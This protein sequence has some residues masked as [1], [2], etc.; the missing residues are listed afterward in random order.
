[1]N[2]E[3][4]ML[5]NKPINFI[6]LKEAKQ[7]LRI[8][9]ENDDEM[10]AHMINIAALAA[11]NYLGLKL[12]ETSWKMTIYNH[13]PISIKFVNKPISKIEQVKFIRNNKEISYLLPDQYFLNNSKDMLSFKRLHLAQ[14]T[15][16]TYHTGY[17]E[18]SLPAT[19]KQGMLEHLARLYDFRGSDH[20]LPLAAK[21]LY[22]PYKQMRL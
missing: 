5:K 17:N 3:I 14:K 10:L 7:Y 2:Q 12:Q 1:M 8:D 22:Q 9:N 19:I 15:E 13:L 11:E 20:G 16:I 6:T 18:T 21:S 4:E